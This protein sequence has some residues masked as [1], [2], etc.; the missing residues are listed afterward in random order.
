[1]ACDIGRKE[2]NEQ[3]RFPYLY[4]SGFLMIDITLISGAN[5]HE[6]IV[7]VLV[8]FKMT[9]SYF[10]LTSFFMFSWHFEYLLIIFWF[11]V[12]IRKFVVPWVLEVC[13]STL[14]FDWFILISYVRSP[15]IIHRQSMSINIFSAPGFGCK[16]CLVSDFLLRNR[17]L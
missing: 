14:R 6:N 16:A 11:S 2:K 7:Q 9:A 17:N 5:L 10:I 4:P 15:D 12:K 3:Y 8:I 13:Y 1:M